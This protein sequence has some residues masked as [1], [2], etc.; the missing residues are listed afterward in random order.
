MITSLSNSKIKNI[1]KLKDRKTRENS[2]L[3]FV[4]GVRIVGEALD[5]KWKIDQ[6]IIAP[7]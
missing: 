7:N 6:A 1:R 3:F 5:Q 4:E 2:G